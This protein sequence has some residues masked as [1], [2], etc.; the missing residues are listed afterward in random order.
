ML[1]LTVSLRR[2]MLLIM[3]RYYKLTR[4]D[5]IRT[6]LDRNLTAALIRLRRIDRAVAVEEL[7]GATRDNS[8]F[9][10]AV[11][12]NQAN[13]NREISFATRGRLPES[14]KHRPAALDRLNDGKYGVCLE[15]AEAQVG[16]LP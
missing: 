13:E 9:A 2:R 16:F 14:V 3:L 5:D 4:L 15:C 10:D 1:G 11:D 12:E 6:R 8:R 7:P